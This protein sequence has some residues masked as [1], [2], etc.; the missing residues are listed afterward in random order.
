MKKL[1]I[2]TAI[3][4][5]VLIPPQIKAESPLSLTG[6]GL[7]TGSCNARVMG[8]GMASLGVQDTLGIDIRYP[9]MWSGSPTAR[10]GIQ[11]SLTR[12][13]AEDIGGSDI[14][15]EAILNGVSFVVPIGN[16]R[17]FGVILSPYTRT[18]YKWIVQDS[19]GY[20][21][22]SET[23]QGR[24]G[25]SQGIAGLSVPLTVNLRLG[26]AARGLFGKIERSWRIEFTDI[27]AN[28]AELTSSDRL[29]GF[30]WGISLY[31]SNL[32]NWSVGAAATSPVE[33]SVERRS[34]V[35][36]SDYS[37]SDTTVDVEENWDLPLEISLGISRTFGRHITA[38]EAR[39]SGWGSLDEPVTIEGDFADAISVS[40]G[41]EWRPA[42]KPLD[43]FLKSLTYRG[44]F[45]Y[46]QHYASNPVGHQ[47]E[48]YALTG[49]ISIPYLDNL[50]RLDIAL[51]LG[52]MGTKNEDGIAERSVKLTVGF[53]H[54]QLWFA[55]RRERN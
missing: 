26:L 48:K 18:N 7:R 39:W 47:A 40:C 24:G 43:P 20:C 23:Q 4:L 55:G 45:Y 22:I 11:S 12:N 33:M 41:W 44:G 36:K 14:S 25:V 52:W 31:G 27:A 15:D 30:G 38:V 19:V 53:N 13:W 29:S 42:Y 6:Y 10:F 1:I 51:E 54:S 50:S 3:A 28:A 46:Q 17:F 32:G 21:A 34:L 9:A 2:L 35:T 5:T 16:E 8:M 37:L 49:G